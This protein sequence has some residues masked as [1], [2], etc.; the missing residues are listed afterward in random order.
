MICS[1]GTT[2]ILIQDADESG[3]CGQ[4]VKSVCLRCTTHAFDRRATIGTPPGKGR[5]RGDDAL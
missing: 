2:M 3:C 4:V 1:C 5:T